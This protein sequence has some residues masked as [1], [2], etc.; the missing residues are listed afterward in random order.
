MR[1]NNN[2]SIECSS[3]RDTKLSLTQTLERLEEQLIQRKKEMKALSS[4]FDDY[5]YN[6]RHLTEMVGV[7]YIS[8]SN[9]KEYIKTTTKKL[10][11][12]KSE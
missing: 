1:F 11:A 5:T 4:M 6:N 2:D 7:C 9:T 8:I 10:K 12:F 3:T